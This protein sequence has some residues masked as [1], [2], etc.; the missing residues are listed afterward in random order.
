MK[1]Y[2]LLLFS[3]LITQH[4]I[5]FSQLKV[6]V[7]GG[8]MAGVSSA[9][10]ISKID[11]TA[12][13]TVFEKEHV[14]GGNAQTV[15]ITN[16]NQLK[17]KVDA[18]PQYFVE[19]PWNEYIAFL[20]EILKK[21][22][23]ETESL[24]GSVLI[25]Q[26]NSKVPN[27]V[28]PLG[29]KLRGEKLKKLLLFKKFNAKAYELYCNSASNSDIT[30]ESWV[31]GLDFTEEFKIN[32]IYPFMAA[33]LGT[34]VST[35]KT[36]SAV[37]IVKLFAFRKPKISNKFKIMS[38]GMGS[39]I[40]L[41]GKQIT[42]PKLHILCNSPVLKLIHSNTNNTWEL[43][44]NQ[45]NQI[46]QEKFDF[47]VFATH[48]DQAAKIIRDVEDLK[49]VES[50]LNQLTYFEAKIALHSDTS[51][52]NNSKPTFLNIFTDQNNDVVWSTMNLSMISKR[53]NGIYKSWVNDSIITDITKKRKL[54]HLV[55]FWHPL[56]TPK[57]I[58]SIKLMHQEAAQIPS[59]YFAGGWSEGLETQNS[60]VIS[61]QHAADKFVQFLRKSTR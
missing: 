47:V 24:S 11:S 22:P 28:S 19:G 51:Y 1:L 10:Y 20:T 52:I 23:F 35:I 37:D 42:T 57:F 48:A 30:V 18:G 44:Y 31:N 46:R 17:V 6:A 5:T 38:E 60:A 55:S 50:H 7:I 4:S 9:Y 15:E 32:I 2:R 27:I 56:I 34:S 54:L 33:S 39:L 26:Q 3:F 16:K 14:L 61:G 13:I 40:Q 53:L 45:D 36:T 25:Q 41:I 21:N 49:Q 58:Q 29:L 59:I 8:G 43:L 12:Q